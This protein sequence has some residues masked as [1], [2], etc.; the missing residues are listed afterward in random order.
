MHAFPF[1][2]I[3]HIL[4]SIIPY[5]A[6]SVYKIS[7]Q[8]GRFSSNH[9]KVLGHKEEVLDIA[10]NPFDDNEIAS[11]SQDHTIKIWRIPDRGLVTTLKVPL[12]TL[13]GHT[14]K[15]SVGDSSYKTIVKTLLWPHY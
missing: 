10:W 3:Y 15:V 4:K 7:L 14:Q 5:T 9:A 12:S 1:R 6:S 2:I 8:C 13:N 11:A